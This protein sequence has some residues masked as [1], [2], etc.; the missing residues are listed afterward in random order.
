MQQLSNTEKYE[1][2][3]SLHGN[4]AKA[5]K[6][7]F[8]YQ[9]IFIE[10]AIAEDRCKSALRHA[11]V[12]FE[13]SRGFE[14]KLSEKIRKLRDNAVFCAR[15]PRSRLPLSLLDELMEWKRDRDGLVHALVN[16][17]YND[18]ALREVA[19][20]GKRITDQL[21]TRVRSVNNYF[22]KMNVPEEK[23]KEE[24]T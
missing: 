20:R 6:L 2:Y 5:M 7:G 23:D 1:V 8:Y 16:R 14:L 10:Y 22:R 3:K 4:L 15:Y 12:K 11:G 9:A 18:E 13:N 17:P 24:T 21:S 19:E